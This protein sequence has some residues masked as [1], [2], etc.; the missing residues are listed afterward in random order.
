MASILAVGL[1]LLHTG[2]VPRLPPSLEIPKP[3]DREHRACRRA[4]SACWWLSEAKGGCDV[5]GGTGGW[6][7]LAGGGPRRR[8]AVFGRRPG[9]AA[10]TMSPQLSGT[11]NVAHARRDAREGAVAVDSGGWKWWRAE[12]GQQPSSTPLGAAMLVQPPSQRHRSGLSTR[13][14]QKCCNSSIAHQTRVGRVMA[15]AQDTMLVQA[16]LR[17]CWRP[18]G[19]GRGSN[20]A[21]VR[22]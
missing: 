2:L 11:R 20:G 1:Q 17:L 7:Q 15:H 3:F 6:Q 13:C 4:S 10:A 14:T 19:H 21:P 12:N 16:L 22:G 5:R 9:S 8:K 18:E